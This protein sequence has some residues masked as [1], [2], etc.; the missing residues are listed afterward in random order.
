MDCRWGGAAVSCARV[1]T[2]AGTAG[3]GIVIVVTGRLIAALVVLLL[4]LVLVL[5]LLVLV[6]LLLLLVLFW[7][8]RLLR[9]SHVPVVDESLEHR[10]SLHAASSNSSPPLPPLLPPPPL[11]P[12]ALRFPA[13]AAGER[14]ASASGP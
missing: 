14:G 4:V 1:V 5:V 11:P 9:A 7:M 3:P 13:P 10:K 12:P 6:L 2:A 8:Q